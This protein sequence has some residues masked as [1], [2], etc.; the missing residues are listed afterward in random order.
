MER[1]NMK[2]KL[3]GMVLVII[4]STTMVGCG[5]KKEEAKTVS[6]ES[7]S[8]Q[9]LGSK[10]VEFV[11]EEI[12]TKEYEM[13]EGEQYRI[14]DTKI[15]SMAEYSP[16]YA[17]PFDLEIPIMEAAEKKMG[18]EERVKFGI[19]DQNLKDY[20][21]LAFD[22]RH[23]KKEDETHNGPR[24]RSGENMA[25]SL[26][27]TDFSPGYYQYN[28]VSNEEYTFF[29]EIMLYGH[30]QRIQVVF[31]VRNNGSVEE[32]DEELFSFNTGVTKVLSV[33]RSEYMLEYA[34]SIRSA[35]LDAMGIDKSLEKATRTE[36]GL[37]MLKE[38]NLEVSEEFLANH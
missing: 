28:S 3:I 33:D 38:W 21:R 19:Y 30:G 7:E 25:E 36:V 9:D 37:E 32:V 12:F 2:K 18:L 15:I 6:L 20:Y 8:K 29:Y 24:Y 35:V 23:G 14:I 17:F 16:G 34:D 27:P 31:H 4:M 22:Y 11:D 10:I 5:S 26:R 13:A 1:K